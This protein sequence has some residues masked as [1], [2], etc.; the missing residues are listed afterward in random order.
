MWSDREWRSE[1][2]QMSGDGE[3]AFIK[4]AFAPPVAHLVISATACLQKI[5]Q[6]C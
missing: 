6:H 2:E 5:A 1:D 3:L 4:E